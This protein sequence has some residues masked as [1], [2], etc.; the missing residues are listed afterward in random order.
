MASTTS[1]LG[2]T[3]PASGEGYSLDVFNQNFQKIDDF[4]GSIINESKGSISSE[5]AL[6]ALLDT[7]IQGLPNNYQKTFQIAMSANFSPFV[8]ATYVCTLYKFGND[9]TYAHAIIRRADAPYVFSASRNPNGWSYERLQA[10]TWI[11]I[12][13]Q[14]TINST[15]CSDFRAYTDRHQVYFSCYAK[16]GTPD[17]TNLVT[18]IS[19]GYRPLAPCAASTFWMNWTDAGKSIAAYVMTSA[20]QIRTESE[21]AGSGGV[22]VSGMYPI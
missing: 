6:S 20:I 5:S 14:F 16:A 22:L 19:T 10:Q 2:L 21:L 3:K 12:S 11:D 9:T 13:S 8:A 4:A 1:K 7:I 18:N 17:Q 15:Y